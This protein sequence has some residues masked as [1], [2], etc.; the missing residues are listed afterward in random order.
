VLAYLMLRQDRLAAA[1]PGTSLGHLRTWWG[2]SWPAQLVV[3]ARGF[4]VH[5][6]SVV[7]PVG[8]RFDSYPPTHG[9]VDAGAAIGFAVVVL[10]VL[11]A[12]W[13]RR[14]APLVSLGLLWFLVAQA[15]TSNVLVP[16]GIPCADRFLYLPLAGAALALAA[17]LVPVL[18]RPVGRI[19]AGAMVVLL[20]AIAFG[21]S[22]AFLDDDVMWV[23]A[24]PPDSPRR[25]QRDY[26]HAHDRVTAAWEAGRKDEA[27][28]LVPES[29]AIAERIFERWREIV[30]A[31]EPVAL[32]GPLARMANLHR[33]AGDRR[34]A[35]A[36]LR[37]AH[38]AGP[39]MPR[40]AYVRG[41]LAHNVGEYER[42]LRAFEIARELRF[43]GDVAEEIG[44]THAS[45]ARRALAAERYGA[46][47]DHLQRSLEAWPASEGNPEA[48]NQA[49]IRREIREVLAEPA[50]P[51]TDL[52]AWLRRGILRGKVGDSRAAIEILGGLRR[53][54]PENPVVLLALARWGYEE[55]GR[56]DAARRI[57]E[58][59]AR[60]RPDD[61][62][63]RMGL[64]RTGAFDAPPTASGAR[65]RLDR[66]DGLPDDPRVLG[67]RA[68]CERVLGR[69][70][71]AL[72]LLT[73]AAEGY[74]PG[75]ID[76]LRRLHELD[77]LE[78]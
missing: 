46:A 38:L 69:E 47:A 15:P 6:A 78:R 8:P 11:G 73:R 12:A 16:V 24:A 68:A 4:L 45:L 17:A 10:A 77:P 18:A 74:G 2:G 40:V 25:I 70:D 39:D 49:R 9:R 23:R 50:P 59:V 71:A 5:V 36:L 44:R 65:A 29:L 56:P 76:A 26:E 57:Y 58:Q 14:R 31:T 52:S 63:A 37:R 43:E 61:T 27:R 32:P 62:A 41:L 28:A 55:A 35:Y 20:A 53:V 1:D 13:A 72:A 67:L 34:R 21:D 3:A 30:P 22:F 7:F 75:V 48:A 33:L 42:A 54:Q 60:L 19:A 64:V 51:R 66:L